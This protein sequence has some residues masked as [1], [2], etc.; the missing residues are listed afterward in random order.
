MATTKLTYA[1]HKR[2]ASNIVKA[3]SHLLR[4]MTIAAPVWQVNGITLYEIIGLL[5]EHKRSLADICERDFPDEKK[6][7]YPWQGS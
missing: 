4:A 6:V 3:S 5:A 2:V 7:Y 1:E